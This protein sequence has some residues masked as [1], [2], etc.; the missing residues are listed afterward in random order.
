[1]KYLLIAP[2]GAAGYKD[3]TPEGKTCL[4]LA[5]TPNM[6]LL[7]KKGR[8]GTLLTIPKGMPSGSE[9]AILSVLGYNPRECFTGRGALE[10]PGLGVKLEKDDIAFRC[11]LITEENG[12]LKDYS[13]G[14]ISDEESGEL[15]R[16][17]DLQLGKPNIKF[18]PGVSYRHLLVLKG[19]NFS[20]D[21][22]MEA[23]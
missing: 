7:A 14:H 6:D 5:K 22:L 12:K 15:M 11:N 23:D 21:F 18:Y 10:A 8:C 4:Q 20:A 13:A 16:L 17:I 9:I 1:M 3:D 19:N 2:D